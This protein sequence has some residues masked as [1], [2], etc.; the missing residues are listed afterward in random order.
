[1]SD[2]P[3]YYRRVM[4]RNQLLG[5]DTSAPVNKVGFDSRPL[6]RGDLRKLEVDQLDDEHLRAYG[7]RAGIPKSSVKQVLDDFFG[8][9]DVTWLR[10]ECQVPPDDRR[11]QLR[12]AEA[13]FVKLQRYLADHHT[14][15]PKKGGIVEWAIAALEHLSDARNASPRESGESYQFRINE[16]MQGCFGPD[17]SADVME[18]NH[19]F[20]EEALELVQSR[21]CTA[22]EAHMLVD[23]VFNRPVGDP[24]QEVGGVMVTLAALC[25]AARL[26]MDRAAEEELSRCWTKIEAIREKQRTKPKSSPLPQ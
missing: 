2:S 22:E 12:E 9:Q 3:M 11:R 17:I 8:P 6:I 14:S 4:S 23:Y 10:Q 20:L 18:R 16:W 7:L 19:R 13:E 21:G 26:D 15:I 5:D 1:M 25:N 24:H